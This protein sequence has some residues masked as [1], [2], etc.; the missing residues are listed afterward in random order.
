MHADKMEDVDAVYSGDIC[1]VFGVDC[2]S[3]D[4]FVLEKEQQISMESIHVPEAVISMAI[5]PK[6]TKKQANFTKAITRFTK[7][8]PTYKVWFDNENKETIA[9]G[10]GELHLEIYAQRM[11]REYDCPIEMGKPKVSFKETL[12]NPIDFDF[13]HKKQTGGRGEFARVIGNL[14]PLDA[15]DNTKLDFI[16]LTTG[17]NVPKPFVPGVKKGFMDACKKGDLSGNSVM[18][19][20]MILRD[21]ANHMVD[22]SEWSFYQAT[23]SAY[24]ECFENGVW[25]ILEPIMLVEVNAPN[26]FSSNIYSLM[27]KRK[28]IIIGQDGRDDW[29]TLE[30]EV[31]LNEMF[32]FSGE[33]RSLTQGKGEY[34]ME[35]SR[36]SPAAV[37]TQQRLINEHQAA[38]EAE[39]DAAAGGA[40]KK[41]KN[42]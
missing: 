5:K 9:S 34:T 23:Q 32:G 39:A 18:G 41:K 7:E 6:D 1:A 29:F 2:A 16:D 35:Y 30:C 22:S 33:L 42:K 10:M 8:D 12:V 28:G 4:S 40:K 37:E 38:L 14:E 25:Q 20:R 3:G 26:E 19:V 17:T 24:H 27:N 21:G 11:E 13:L 36:Y 15:R 31:P